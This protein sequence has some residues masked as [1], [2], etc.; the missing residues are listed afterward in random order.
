VIFFSSI[1]TK[2]DKR[3]FL[4]LLLKYQESP[5]V[6]HSTFFDVVG[7]AN[8]VDIQLLMSIV[9]FYFAYRKYERSKHFFL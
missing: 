2:F 8:E 3:L 4:Y 7:I 5:F 1:P 9:F 6:V